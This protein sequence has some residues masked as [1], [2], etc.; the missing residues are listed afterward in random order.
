[1][2]M[3]AHQRASKSENAADYGG[4]LWKTAGKQIVA[5]EKEIQLLEQAM[6]AIGGQHEQVERAFTAI[7]KHLLFT[8]LF[9]LS[10]I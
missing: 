7:V 6:S 8:N 3:I 4:L 9:C 5:L 10:N 2:E 1:M